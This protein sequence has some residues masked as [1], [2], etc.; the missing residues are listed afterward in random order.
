MWI[1]MRSWA[2]KQLV[3]L[4]LLG[5]IAACTSEAL[6]PLSPEAV[7]HEL[8]Q[9]A[10]GAAN[11]IPTLATVR[12]VTV[13]TTCENSG[14]GPVGPAT[15]VDLRLESGATREEVLG[16][17]TRMFED[18]GYDT[19]VDPNDSTLLVGRRQ[20]TPLFSGEIAVRPNGQSSELLVIGTEV[21]PPTRC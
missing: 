10:I 13:V 17:L 15:R 18:R 5:G 7:A 2:R 14:S 6:A 12:D 3:T 19:E 16:E 20:F 8:S 1:P 4:V 11:S 9:N 21:L